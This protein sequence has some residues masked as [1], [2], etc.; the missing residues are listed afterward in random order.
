MRLLPA[1]LA[2]A[3]IVVASNVLVQFLLWDGLLTWG[4]FTYPLAFLVNDVT[5]RRRGPAAARTVVLWGFVTGILC[6]LVG[7]RVMLETGP[8]VP[9]RI[10]VASGAAFL[11]AQ[12][13]DIAV[14]QRLRH[15]AWWRAPL[16]S[17]LVSSAADTLVFFGTAFS[18][19]MGALFP[20]AA[21]ATVAWALTPVPLLGAGHEAPLWASLALADYGVKVLIALV[22]LIPFRLLTRHWR[23]QPA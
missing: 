8:A 2:M 6:S 1:I 14:F 19:A 7:S 13:L 20:A 22:A 3:A 15:L 17:P 10:G 18:A 21:D 5:N 23:P 4:A 9:L 11:V 12:L 16:V